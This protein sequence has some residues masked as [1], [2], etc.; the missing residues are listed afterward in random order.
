MIKIIYGI[1]GER[2]KFYPIQDKELLNLYQN[3]K[4][5]EDLKKIIKESLKE[6]E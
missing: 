3:Y 5:Q 1:Q 4:I 6:W 2:F